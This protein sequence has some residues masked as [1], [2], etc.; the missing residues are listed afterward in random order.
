MKS[1]DFIAKRDYG[2]L[3][4]PFGHIGGREEFF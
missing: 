1:D 2:R 4:A 3:R